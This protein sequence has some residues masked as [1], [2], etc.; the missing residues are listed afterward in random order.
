MMEMEFTKMVA[1]GND[2]IIIDNRK[3]ASY[4]SG[5]SINDVAKKFCERK[6]SVGADGLLLIEDSKRGDFK[7]RVFNPDGSE[8]DMCGNGS[9]CTALYAVE[10]HIAPKAMRIETRAGLIDA[11]VTGLRVKIKLTDPKDLRLNIRLNIGKK[12]HKIHFVNTGVPHVVYFF[13]DID[14]LNVKALGSRTRFHK[15][16]GPKGANANFAEVLSPKE[17]KVRTYERGVEDETYACGTGA[18]ASAVISS[19]LYGFDSHIDVRTKSGEVLRVYFERKRRS[20]KNVY[21][22]GEAQ[23]AYRGRI[24][25]V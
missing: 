13:K 11:E 19:L 6:M 7:M 24:S 20:I 12:T 4:G 14:K 10:N 18:T 1:S 23:V 17:I 2:F 21:L 25:H 15:T 3:G 5:T 22:E 16:F 9:R 8:V